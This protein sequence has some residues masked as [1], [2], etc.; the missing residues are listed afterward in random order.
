MIKYALIIGSLLFTL[1]AA[2]QNPLEQ[3]QAANQLY[4]EEKY[5]DAIE[6]YESLLQQGFPLP[7]PGVWLRSL[8]AR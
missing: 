1:M 6:S 8:R 7:A 4:E 3:F 5:T 2:A